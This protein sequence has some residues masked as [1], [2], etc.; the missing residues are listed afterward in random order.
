MD[1][2][3]LVERRGLLRAFLAM[4]GSGLISA[5]LSGCAANSVTSGIK[6]VSGD[7]FVNDKAVTTANLVA[8]DATVTTGD[9]GVA[10]FVVGKD[11]F[12]LRKNSRITLKPQISSPSKNSSNPQISGFQIHSGALMSVFAPGIRRL[13]TPTAVV[14]VRGTGVYI[15]A[16]AQKS[17]ICTC[18]GSV[19]I[20]ALDGAKTREEIKTVHHDS[21]RIIYA[22]SGRIQE[23]PMVNHKDAELILLEGLVGR[24]PPF[25]GS[26]GKVDNGY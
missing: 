13:R 10:V 3:F 26:W 21:P 6:R 1:S 19:S 2:F 5:A 8:T 20:E 11:A 24:K 23:A 14:G 22:D 12:L 18:Y 15:E 7:V 9:S 17:Y 16:S 25:V 4:G